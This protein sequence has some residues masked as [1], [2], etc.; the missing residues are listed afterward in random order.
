LGSISTSFNCLDRPYGYYADQENSCRVFH[1]CYPALFSNG[2]VET[3]QYSF[4]CGEGSQ[5]DQKELTCVA[6][7]EAIPCNES[8]SFFFRNEQFGRTEEKTF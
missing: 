5:F 8:S 3:Y 1:I 4:M 7:L 2:A 6:E